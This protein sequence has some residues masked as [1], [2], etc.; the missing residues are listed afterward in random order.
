MKQYR[1]KTKEG[2]LQG[3]VMLPSS[4]SI[5]NRL[6]VMRSM[7]KSMVLFDNLSEADDTYMMRLYLS[8]IG[9]CSDSKIPMVMDAKN[10]GTVFRFLTAFL[11]QR[12]GKWLLT[13]SERMKQRP[14]NHL[15][16]ALR[17]L[18]AKIE[19]TEKEGYPPLMVHGT[20]LTGSEVEVD[21]SDSSQ[22][23]SALLLIAPHFKNGLKLR[24]KG[25]VVSSSYLKMTIELMKNFLV[26]VE[27]KK[28]EIIVHPGRYL[29]RKL[30]VESD[31]SSAAFWYQIV[32]SQ[33]KSSVR[34]PGLKEKSVQGDRFLVEVFNHLGVRTEF[35]ENDAV[36]TH[37][38]NPDKEIDMDFSS[39]PDI[40]PSVMT[41]C[42]VLGVKARFRGIEHLRIKESDRIGAMQEELAK[43]GVEITKNG[44]F[45]DLTSGGEVQD[46]LVFNSHADHRLAMCLAPLALHF[47]AVS[48]T[49][50]EV[51]TKSYPHYWD[52]LENSGI[53]E[54]DKE[55]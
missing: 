25:E 8:F 20:Q 9:T 7:E 43:I 5:S 45:Y 21:A 26:E 34:L 50:P 39:A 55:V 28:N 17:K 48:I 36:L 11:A 49:N 35:V 53:F 52:D 4:K 37:V 30:T 2:L 44:N 40:V 1:I 22:F 47:D 46:Q 18:G 54:I 33:K 51:V 42:A 16:D 6:L 15:V 19:Y 29:V 13:G 12:K 23:I 10:A 38:G 3:K 41:A 32:A 31:W 27:D 14:V 24:L